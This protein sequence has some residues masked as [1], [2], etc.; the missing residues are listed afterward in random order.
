[1]KRLLQTVKANLVLGLEFM[2]SVDAEAVKAWSMT[3]CD[4]CTTSFAKRPNLPRK[5]SVAPA[6]DA[7]DDGTV[8]STH[9]L[10]RDYLRRGIVGTAAAER[11]S[12]QT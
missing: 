6:L 2:P 1:M 3:G 11:R 9:H 10:E 8:H 12:P 4:I 5:L 7:N